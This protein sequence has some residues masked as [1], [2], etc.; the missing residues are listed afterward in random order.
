MPGSLPGGG[1]QGPQ[2]GRHDF[3]TCQPWRPQSTHPWKLGLLTWEPR[4]PLPLRSAGSLSLYLTS[5]A[6]EGGGPIP[7]AT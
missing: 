6:G 3:S 5:S 1:F 4:W 7:M 2:E